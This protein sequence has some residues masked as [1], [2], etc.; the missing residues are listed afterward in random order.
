MRSRCRRESWKV[1]SG[2]RKAMDLGG[3]KRCK[4]GKRLTEK[5]QNITS[6]AVWYTDVRK[7]T[8]Q[9]QQ[10]MMEICKSNLTGFH[11]WAKQQSYMGRER[12]SGGENRKKCFLSFTNSIEIIIEVQECNNSLKH[13][14]YSWVQVQM[15]VPIIALSRAFKSLC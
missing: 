14:T 12:W 4:L 3:D 10:M 8:M 13:N 1:E 5:Q 2:W 9:M 7:G 15:W 6:G 11:F